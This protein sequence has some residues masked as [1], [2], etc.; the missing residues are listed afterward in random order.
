[1]RVAQILA[2]L[3]SNAVKFTADGEVVIEVG[4]T[5]RTDETRLGVL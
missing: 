3:V 1:M 5:T 4:V 2:N